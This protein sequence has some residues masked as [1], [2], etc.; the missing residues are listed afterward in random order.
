MV[1]IN[2]ATNGGDDDDD[3]DH[4]N[5]DDGDDAG[6][7]DDDDYDAKQWPLYPLS[8]LW[9]PISFRLPQGESYNDTNFWTQTKMM[10]M[11]IMT[12][13]LTIF[14]VSLHLTLSS[15]Q[16]CVTSWWDNPTPWR[17]S[18]PPPMIS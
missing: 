2:N 8:R 18:A 13:M 1:S 11:I 7:D 10:I 17:L 9:N 5:D 15:H 16:P 12:I 4:G 14:T 3:D 6:N